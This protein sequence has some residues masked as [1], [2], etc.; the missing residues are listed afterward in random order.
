LI[1]SPE[2]EIQLR[3][4]P[5][6]APG[7]IASIFGSNLTDSTVCIPPSCGPT[8]DSN[9]KAISTTASARVSFNGIAAPILST[10]SPSQLNVQIPVELAGAPSATV[11][12]T[13]SGQSSASS[14]VLLAPLSLGLISINSSGAGQGAILNDKDANQGIQSLV[15][16]ASSAPN[17][18]PAARGD[19]IEIY[20]T[21]LGVV[22]PSVPTGVR[23]SGLPQTVTKPTVTIGGIPANVVFSGLASCCVGLNQVNVQ[24]PAGSPTGSA[25]PVVLATGGITSNTVTIAVQ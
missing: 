10:P 24:V 17:A 12:V 23:P 5:S 14:I 22:A 9:G 1:S 19:V 4:K 8:F 16:P 2:A 20:G 3:F 15:A 13:V 21:G 11:Q 25:V 6:L 7:S 18:H